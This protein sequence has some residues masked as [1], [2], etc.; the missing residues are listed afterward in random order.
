M[1]EEVITTQKDKGYHNRTSG[2]MSSSFN[3]ELGSSNIPPHER[4][5]GGVLLPL[6]SRALLHCSAIGGTMRLLLCPPP[7]NR[8]SHYGVMTA[9]ISGRQSA[10]KSDVVS[11]F[12]P[13]GHGLRSLPRFDQK[14]RYLFRLRLKTYTPTLDEKPFQVIRHSFP[15]NPNPG[16]NATGLS[17]RHHDHNNTGLFYAH[18]RWLM[19]WPGQ[20]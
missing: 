12:P 5:G 1:I 10:A 11:F 16:L 13:P 2:E 4:W 17:G 20:N 7:P 15:W 18:L 8:D 19:R 9:P 6:S 14:H 3:L